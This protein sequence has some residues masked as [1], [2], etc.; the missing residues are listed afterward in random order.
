MR[1][2]FCGEVISFSMFETPGLRP[3]STVY[4]SKSVDYHDV[5]H[6]H[7]ASYHEANPKD[8]LDEAR[9]ADTRLRAK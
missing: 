7:V 8:C 9:F 4:R 6:M 5:E 3:C 2:G 1:Q